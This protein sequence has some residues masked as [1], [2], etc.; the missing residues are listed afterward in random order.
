MIRSI[1]EPEKIKELAEIM[2]CNEDIDA[3]ISVAKSNE[4]WIRSLTSRASSQS[5]SIEQLAADYRN[6]K[7]RADRK[8]KEADDAKADSDAK[9]K[10]LELTG[11]TLGLAVSPITAKQEP[12][13]VIKEW[14][15]LQVGD[16]VFII[17][18][19]NSAWERLR[20]LEMVVIS[21]GD[22]YDRLE[23]KSECG[24]E[25]YHNGNTEFK[26]IRRP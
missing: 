8:Q 16:V 2:G 24:E 11:E 14:R 4:D 23:F 1:P 7:D 15:D 19:Q 9:L 17:A 20:N 13:L 3:I 6:A 12:E 26:F 18:S 21:T 5:G 10:A 22:T 25:W